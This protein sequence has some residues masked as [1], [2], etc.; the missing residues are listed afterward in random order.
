MP[1]NTLTKL[2]RL[3]LAVSGGSDSMALA[4]MISQT[5]GLSEKTTAYTVD[6]GVRSESSSEAQ[7]VH[8]IVSRLGINHRILKLDALNDTKEL[9][10]RQAR[11][12]KLIAAMNDDG[13]S[14]VVTAHTQDDCIETFVVRM[15]RG[16]GL[17]GLAGIQPRVSFN[18]YTWG[19]GGIALK[20]HSRT[21]L[22]SG[23]KLMRPLLG[24]TKSHL[25][26]VLVKNNIP[27]FEDPTNQNVE[28][29]ERNLV[30]K[31][32][33]E[34]PELI[35]E[36]FQAS[37]VLRLLE[38]LNGYRIKCETEASEVS[39]R[40]LAASQS[41][42]GTITLSEEQVK[43][44]LTKL[45]HDTLQLVL[46]NIL[47]PLSPLPDLSLR[48][49]RLRGLTGRFEA[50]NKFNL[51]GVD[52]SLRNDKWQLSREV[53]RRPSDHVVQLTPGRVSLWD[54]RFFVVSD[55]PKATVQFI[56]WD[57]HRE[58]FKSKEELNKARDQARKRNPILVYEGGY[59][60]PAL[61]RGVLNTMPK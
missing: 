40:L 51:A 12:S 7:N 26:N 20:Q 37:N 24:L 15:L 29:A 18:P 55:L 14:T 5:P 23:W 41:P 10:M 13:V 22:A 43:G 1:L 32:Y 59:S 19:G 2:P 17:F 33:Y 3:A 16:S 30:R 8:E 28:I 38:K 46:R 58:L 44:V 36:E 34:Y 47:S 11:Y 31:M 39:S 61:Q 53:P 49:H 9:S 42:D 45:P 4:Y 56:D 35:P 25:R 57:S 60:F 6:H 50:G 48:L 54:N 27:W 21:E 52:F